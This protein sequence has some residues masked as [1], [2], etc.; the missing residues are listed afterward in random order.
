MREPAIDWPAVFGDLAHLGITGTGL[1]ERVGLPA[2]L[3]QRVAA[4]KARPAPLAAERIAGLW[5]EATGKTAQFLPK[6]NGV[7]KPPPE[8]PNLLSDEEQ[9]PAYVQIEAALMVWARTTG[10]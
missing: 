3:L 7:R 6:L 2:G 5:I 10:Q 1:C 9:E 8:I 4:G